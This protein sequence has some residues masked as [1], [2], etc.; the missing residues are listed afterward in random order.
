MATNF[1]E[2]TDRSINKRV[3]IN[4]DWIKTVFPLGDGASIIVGD[5]YAV[6]INE[7]QPERYDV[8]ETY[9]AVRALIMST[10][11]VVS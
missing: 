2:V 4:V 5:G 7:E 11:G 8:V 10:N 3:L 1:I 6:P 9:G